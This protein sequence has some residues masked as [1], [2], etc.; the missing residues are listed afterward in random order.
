MFGQ[1]AFFL[2]SFVFCV[3]GFNACTWLQEHP[4][5]IVEEVIEDVI[6]EETGMDVDLTPGS[7]EKKK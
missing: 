3:L 5:N 7:P 2:G 1:S 6:Q 4:D